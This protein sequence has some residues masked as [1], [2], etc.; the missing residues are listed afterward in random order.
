MKNT[1]GKNR[2]REVEVQCKECGGRRTT[3]MQCDT[4]E[5]EWECDLCREETTHAV[6]EVSPQAKGEE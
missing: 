1:Y 4:G 6:T 5:Y 2:F 3:N